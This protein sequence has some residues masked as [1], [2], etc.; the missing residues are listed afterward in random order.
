MRDGI[1]RHARAAWALGGLMLVGAI[2]APLA[3]AAGGGPIRAEQRNPVHGTYSQQTLIIADNDTYATRQSN[4]GTG[5]GAVYGCRTTPGNEPCVRAANLR[6][7]LAFRFETA[8]AVGGLI[9]VG[10]G[11]DKAKPFTTNATGVATGLNADRVDGLN[12]DQIIAAAKGAGTATCPS[13]TV[14]FGGACFERTTRGVE[15]FAAASATC[16]TAGRRLPTGSEL[17]GLRGVNGVA[18]TGAEMASDLVSNGGAAAY[19]T[20]SQQGDLASQS[21]GTGSAFRCVAPAVAPAS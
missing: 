7:G 19:V 13:G 14:A 20:V 21:P 10:S 2:A 17:L 12:A 15:N 3:L 1:R 9:A 6:S 11:G 16:G 5:G 18:L 8:G 4:K